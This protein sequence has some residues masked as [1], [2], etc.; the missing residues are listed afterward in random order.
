MQ[1]SNYP[2][3]E[4]NNQQSP[5]ELHRRSDKQTTKHPNREECKGN[6]D[7]KIPGSKDNYAAMD[8]PDRKWE[9]WENW[10]F[11]DDRVNF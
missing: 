10:Q 2:G 1:L 11:S 9:E 7:M 8:T 5:T 3:A 4:D 6:G